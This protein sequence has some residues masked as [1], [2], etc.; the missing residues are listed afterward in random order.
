MEWPLSKSTGATAEIAAA[1]R[2]DIRLLYLRGAARGII[3]EYPWPHLADTDKSAGRS[4]L[5]RETPTVFVV[6][7]DGEILGIRVGAN[8][9]WERWLGS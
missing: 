2:F 9:D 5:V 6:D 1:K 4:L 3:A 7:G 8:V